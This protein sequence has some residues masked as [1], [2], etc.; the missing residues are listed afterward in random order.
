MNVFNLQPL[1]RYLHIFQLEEYKTKRLLVWV[2]KNL[3]KKP[4]EEKKPIIWTNKAKLLYLGSLMLFLISSFLLI[5]YFKLALAIIFIAFLW[6]NYLFLITSTIILKIY[7]IPN[8]KRVKIKTRNKIRSMTNLKVI[9]I[10][11][12]AGKTTTKNILEELLS[13]KV[14]ATPLSYNTLFGIAKVV[15]YELNEKYKFFICEMGAYKK[16]EIKELCKITQPNIGIVTS[17]N[18]QHLERFGSIDNTIK[19][20]FEML[21]NLKQGGIGI[22]NLDNHYIRNNLS[23]AKTNLIGFTIDGNTSSECKK[24]VKLANWKVLDKKMYFEVSSDGKLTKMETELLGKHHLYNLLAAITC[25]IYLKENIEDI[26]KKVKDI[27]Q[28]PHRLE[29]RKEKGTNILDDTYSS[30]IEGFRE[31]LEVLATFRG[32]KILVTPGIVELGR[33]TDILHKQ[34]GNKAASVCERVILV[35]KSERTNALRKGLLSAGFKSQK[36]ISVNTNSQV[37]K[38]LEKILRAG[39]T[40]LFENDLPDQYL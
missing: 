36:I 35:G 18:T 2:L 37:K 29:L 13:K 20:K 24:I 1:K 26:A 12:S 16:G 31:A 19:A 23:Y 6:C 11:G 21:Q 9:G 3:T 5:S 14:L 30:N 39:D 10:T 15:D 7:E 33:Q 22:V 28:I 8:R 4:K 34:L 32:R 38:H 40:V 27:K 17:V 25:A